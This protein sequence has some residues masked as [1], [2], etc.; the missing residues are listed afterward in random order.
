MIA[1]RRRPRTPASRCVALTPEDQPCKE[2][3]GCAK[4]SQAG[5]LLLSLGGRD[6]VRCASCPAANRT[7]T[8][9]GLHRHEGQK[10]IEGVAYQRR[11]GGLSGKKSVLEYH[12]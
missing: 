10:K 2:A 5:G 8:V 9:L 3:T 4:G 12:L 11:T 6:A 1:S 7:T